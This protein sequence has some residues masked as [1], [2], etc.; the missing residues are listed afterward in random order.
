MHPP[1]HPPCHA[2]LATILRANGR[3]T[4]ANRRVTRAVS[5]LAQAQREGEERASIK[6]A[7]TERESLQR[8][9]AHLQQEL[10][11]AHAAHERLQETILRGESEA[12]QLRTAVDDAQHALA[13]ERVAAGSRLA[14]AT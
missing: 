11:S 7:A 12:R 4:R 10:D 8:R 3:V 1:R 14:D 5:S 13:S 9:A 2:P 6:L